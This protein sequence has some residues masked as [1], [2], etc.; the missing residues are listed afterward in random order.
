MKKMIYSLLVVSTLLLAAG[1][2]H[3]HHTCTK[4]CS[5]AK[6]EECAK[7]G[8]CKTEEKVKKEECDDCKKGS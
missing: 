7:K 4:D 6:K 3:K 2:A 8:G 5:E 1:C